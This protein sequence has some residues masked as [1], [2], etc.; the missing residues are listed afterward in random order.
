[1]NSFRG[2]QGVSAR[3]GGASYML[4]SLSII[5]TAAT[6]GAIIEVEMEEEKVGGVLLR[7]DALLLSTIGFIQ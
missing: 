5:K 7:L 6:W 2:T 3:I 4:G 1:M